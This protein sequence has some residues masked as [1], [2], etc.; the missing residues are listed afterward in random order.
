MSRKVLIISACVTIIGVMNMF[1]SSLDTDTRKMIV[2]AQLVTVMC[3]LM[4]LWT[5]Y[6]LLKRVVNDTRTSGYLK[7][8]A[9]LIVYV[10]YALAMS[11]IPLSRLYITSDIVN[12]ITY[13][14]FALFGTA[15][16]DNNL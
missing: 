3:T 6:Y 12:Y 2:M 13:T 15:R 1:T 7:H 9:S 10:M 16:K 11:S 8:I 14:A 4:T 5:K